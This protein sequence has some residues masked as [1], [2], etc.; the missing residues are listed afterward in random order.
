MI[1]RKIKK[2][3]LF[4]KEVLLSERTARDVNRLIALNRSSINTAE[5]GYAEVVIEAAITIEDALK[6][7]YVFLP[8]YKFLYKKWFKWRFSSRRILDN[9]SSQQIFTLAGEVYALE[10]VNPEKKK[11]TPTAD[12]E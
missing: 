9:L 6:V 10:G 11:P 3:S 5:R 7:N 4:G 12:N 1:D 2:I 8:W